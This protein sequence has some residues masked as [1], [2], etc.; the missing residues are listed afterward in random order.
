[1]DT[2]RRFVRLSG[3]RPNGFVEFEFAIGEPEI[4]VEMILGRDAFTEFCTTN[5]VE[6]LPPREA[7]AP[8]GDWDWRLADA[9]HTRFR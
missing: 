7:D 2:T 5:R 9:T 4:F 1:M 6:M 3:E 8:Q